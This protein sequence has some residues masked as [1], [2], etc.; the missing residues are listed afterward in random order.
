MR[1]LVFGGAIVLA[2]LVALSGCDLMLQRIFP[3]EVG[4]GSLL[5]T[6]QVTD[7]RQSAYSA[8]WDTTGIVC[9][10]LLRQAASGAWEPAA[11]S[12]QK[13]SLEATTYPQAGAS[14]HYEALPDG[15]YHVHIWYDADLDGV[16]DD[17]VN[18]NRNGYWTNDHGWDPVQI[19]GDAPQEATYSM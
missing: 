14:R 18:S 10:E 2:V 7:V 12:L 5:V 8:T 1:K 19:S 4:R 11:G 16:D 15:A 17:A 13:L 3:D 9:V 6:V